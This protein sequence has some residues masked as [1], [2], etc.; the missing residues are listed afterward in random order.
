MLRGWD[1]YQFIAK[2]IKELVSEQ[3]LDVVATTANVQLNWA[4]TVFNAFFGW[5]EE[6]RPGGATMTCCVQWSVHPCVQ[7][8]IGGQRMH[9]YQV[10]F[11][12]YPEQ[13]ILTSSKLAPCPHNE[14]KQ[15]VSWLFTG[16]SKTDAVGPIAATESLGAGWGSFSHGCSAGSDLRASASGCWRCVHEQSTENSGNQDQ[17]SHDQSAIHLHATDSLNDKSLMVM[18]SSRSIW[19]PGRT[20]GPLRP[21]SPRLL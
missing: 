20:Q 14:D 6:Q 12:F 2:Q 21:W 10:T 7:G 4:V 18:V 17:Q 15:K 1:L 3:G 5:Y 11:T 19:D 13:N 9:L 8:S 16:Y